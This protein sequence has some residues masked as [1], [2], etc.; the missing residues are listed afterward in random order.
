MQPIEKKRKVPGSKL[1]KNTIKSLKARA[2]AQL[3]QGIDESRSAKLKK[4][5]SEQLSR[6]RRRAQVRKRKTT[7]SRTR[8][9][10]GGSGAKAQCEPSKD[11]VKARESTRKA[12]M[13]VQG[14]VVRSVGGTA[15]VSRLGKSI[16]IES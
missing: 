12:A 5:I 3:T 10:R 15:G 9:R 14:N 6:E 13:S 16:R 7:V 1:V 11:P 2:S 8:S 4:N